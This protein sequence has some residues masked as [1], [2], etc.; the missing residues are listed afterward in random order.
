MT[1]R[2]HPALFPSDGWYDWAVTVDGVTGSGK[3][4]FYGSAWRKA[5][6]RARK[7]QKL[8]TTLDVDSL[9]DRS[10]R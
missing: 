7:I 2:W 1:I 3:A 5:V 9:I 6:R 8:K 10:E 4:S